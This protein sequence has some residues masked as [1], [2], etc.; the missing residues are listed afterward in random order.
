MVKILAEVIHQAD[1]EHLNWDFYEDADDAQEYA[2]EKT[3]PGRIVDFI[4][5]EYKNQNDAV[6][7]TG[8][9]TT[10]ASRR[11]LVCWF[12]YCKN[13]LPLSV[14]NSLEKYWVNSWPDRSIIDELW[15]EIVE[16]AENG[17][18][19]IDCRRQDTISASSAVAHAARFAK[20]QNLHDAITSLSHA[21][22]AID[23]SPVGS[24]VPYLDW[25]VKI[26]YPCAVEGRI[27]SSK[28][29]YAFA[30]FYFPE[31]MRNE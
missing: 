4:L 25:F 8:L 13:E 31:E 16:P 5:N 9:L 17:N 14:A 21:F 20:K 27:M 6:R 29:M 19:I 2:R 24:Y 11:S 1:L 23:V 3:V 22:N 30:D 18:P 7:V 28:N 15:L 26:A 10:F 12:H